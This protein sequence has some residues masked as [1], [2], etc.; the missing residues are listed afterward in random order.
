MNFIIILKRNVFNYF[1]TLCNF[2]YIKINRIHPR[3]RIRNQVFKHLTAVKIIKLF[4]KHL[5]SSWFR[6][7]YSK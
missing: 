5:A 6:L 3:Y 7:L 1:I 4:I 2:S